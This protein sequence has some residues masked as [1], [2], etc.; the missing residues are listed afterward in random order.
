M[1]S[2]SESALGAYINLS[3]IQYTVVGIFSDDG[4]DN[5][6]RIIYMPVT[7]AQLLYGNNDYIYQINLGYHQ[8]LCVE[9]TMAFSIK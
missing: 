5:E 8:D 4:N 1:F 3:G 7:T 9:E 2:S 6:E